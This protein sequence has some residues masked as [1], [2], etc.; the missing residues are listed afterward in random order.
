MNTGPRNEPSNNERQEDTHVPTNAASADGGTSEQECEVCGSLGWVG[1]DEVRR[2]PQGCEPP[3]NASAGSLSG[4]AVPATTYEE[5]FDYAA[6]WPWVPQSAVASPPTPKENGL[7]HIT[8]ALYPEEQKRYNDQWKQAVSKPPPPP[9]QDTYSTD[10][11]EI[12]AE[13]TDSQE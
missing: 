11:R 4:T 2:C 3:V 12:D 6:V 5:R 9:P 10:V 1:G 8:D 7:L 13:Y